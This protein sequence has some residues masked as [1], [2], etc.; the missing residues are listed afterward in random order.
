M[1]RQREEGLR[2]AKHRANVIVKKKYIYIYIYK[3]NNN[4]K[5]KS[6]VDNKILHTN[7]SSERSVS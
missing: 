5:K 1:K 3:N 6:S 2:N 4:N 7:F